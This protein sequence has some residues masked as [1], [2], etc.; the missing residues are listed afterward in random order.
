MIGAGN[1]NGPPVKLVG[2]EDHASHTPQDLSSVQHLRERTQQMSFRDQL[3]RN[4]FVIKRTYAAS[5][6]L[7]ESLDAHDPCEAIAEI[8]GN[9]IGSEE[10]AIFRYIAAGE[11]FSVQWSCGVVAGT[12]QQFSSG[13]GML[14]RTVYTAKSQYRDRQEK[15][16]L[17]PHEKNLTA[18][19]VLKS[20]NEV[21]GAIALFGLL[22]Q[23]GALEWADFE[24]LKFLETYAAVALQFYWL[25]R[26]QV[27]P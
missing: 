2:R 15:N 25:Q 9:L 26:E 5:T 10:I 3:E 8:V 24:L 7:I 21:V 16:L 14:G 13:A 11:I 4:Y 6:R 12:L 27:A 19:I 1:K 18:C 20:G 23:K 22:P 17:L